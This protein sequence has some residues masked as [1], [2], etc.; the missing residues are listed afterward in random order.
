MGD[1][2]LKEEYNFRINRLKGYWPSGEYSANI[3]IILTERNLEVQCKEYKEKVINPMKNSTGTYKINDIL[4]AK[5]G[6]IFL[7]FVPQVILLA[8]IILLAMSTL[9]DTTYKFVYEPIVISIILIAIYIIPTRLKA[10][11]INLKNGEK[12]YI[13]IKSLRFESIEEKE[14]AQRIIDEINYLIKDKK[15]F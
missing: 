11:K 15:V 10:I 1:D 5:Y 4:R 9:F 12:I 7:I 13:P 2:N 8:I 3:K 14:N 6:N